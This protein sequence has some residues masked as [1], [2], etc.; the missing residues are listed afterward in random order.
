MWPDLSYILHDLFGTTPDNAF[1]IIKTFG[2]FLALA[3][4]GSA[5]TLY[6]EF[7]RKEREGVLTSTKV[8][9][10][11]G[12]PATIFELISN[13]I[14]GFILGF[15]LLYI[16]Q[17]FGEFKANAASVILSGTGSWVGG[18]IGL[19][20]GV[21]LKYWEKKKVERAEPIIREMEV[22][23]SERVGDI[24]IVAAISGLIGARLFSIFESVAAINSFIA[25]PFGQLFSGSGLA[26]YGGLIVAFFVV[27]YYIK[28]VLK[29]TPIQVMDAAAP[30]LLIGYAIGRLGCH[31]SGD[32]DW[33]IVNAMPVPSWFILPDWL[34]SYDYPH[35]VNHDGIEIVGCEWLYCQKLAAP[36]FPTPL[37]ETTFSLMIFALLW[38]L[39]KKLKTP[40]LLFF[41][42]VTLNGV[43]RFFIEKIRVNDKISFA[44]INATQAEI[45]ATLL[46]FIGIIGTYYLVRKGKKSLA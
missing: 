21:F 29:I 3:F 43:E 12:A 36:V 8:T 28:F 42:Y 41:I 16:I 25:D 13:A 18:F 27:Y 40:G 2:L 35:N 45:I 4:I 17:H 34:W 38:S 19:A 31:F 30:A 15:K 37:Y 44:G 32:G 24:T 23:P 9:F 10:I 5:Y 14:F 46:I 7:R 26:I 20:L 6:L 33:G 1:S 39:R 11:E 22:F